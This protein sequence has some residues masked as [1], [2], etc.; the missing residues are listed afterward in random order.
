MVRQQ[1][2]TEHASMGYSRCDSGLRFKRG[3][4]WSDL[5]DWSDNARQSLASGFFITEK[6]KRPMASP[7]V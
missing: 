5:S 6:P 7:W 3:S 2:S 1:L 4:D